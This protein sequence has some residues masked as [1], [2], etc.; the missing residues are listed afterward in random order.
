M[1]VNKYICV[2]ACMGLYVHANFYCWWFQEGSSYNLWWKY[3]YIFVYVRMS[4]NICTYMYTTC[5]WFSISSLCLGLKYIHV[6]AYI[7]VYNHI[8][9]YICTYVYATSCCWLWIGSHCLWWKN[10]YICV[11][12]Y[13]YVKACN[14]LFLTL[15]QQPLSRVEVHIYNLIHMYFFI[16]YYPAESP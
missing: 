7:G 3:M 10:I 1:Y 2:C 8:Y 6:Y 11:Y 16:N 15:N 9:V 13:V 4:V 12:K 14:L 5:F